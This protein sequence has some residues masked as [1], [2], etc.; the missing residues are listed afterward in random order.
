[1]Y[2]YI[3]MDVYVN[4]DVDMYIFGERKRGIKR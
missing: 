4:I 1:M 2:I 3:H